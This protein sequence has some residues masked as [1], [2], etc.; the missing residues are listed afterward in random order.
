MTLSNVTRRG[1]IGGLAAGI[2][3]ATVIS[4]NTFIS[5]ARAQSACRPKC[6]WN[7]VWRVLRKHEGIVSGCKVNRLFS[8]LC[9]ERLPTIHLRMLIC[10]EAS[11]AQNNIAGGVGGWQNSLSS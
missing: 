5:L 11:S 3:A 10:P 2:S 9:G 7:L 6:G 1:M 8:G 4:S